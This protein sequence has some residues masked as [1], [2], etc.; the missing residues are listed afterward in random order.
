MIKDT[1]EQQGEEIRRVGSGRGPKYRSRGASPVLVCGHPLNPVLLGSWCS[2]F[3]GWHAQSL[4][5]SL[6]KG[7]GRAESSKLPVM[8]CLSGDHLPSRSPPRV[9]LE[10]E[11]LF[12]LFIA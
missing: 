7:T 4:T 1:G 9:S 2:R 10:Q 6:E 5:P 3:L 8:P 12:V 11:M